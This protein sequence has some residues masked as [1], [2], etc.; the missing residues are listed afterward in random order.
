MEQSENSMFRYIVNLFLIAVI[1]LVLYL[2]YRL[3]SPFLACIF[4]A[5]ILGLIFYPLYKWLLVRTRERK[6]LSSLLTCVVITLCIIVPVSL[7][8]G[9]LTTQSFELYR[10]IESKIADGSLEEILDF[11]GDGALDTLVGRAVGYFDIDTRQLVIE[12]SKGLQSVSGS[13]FSAGSGLVK[14]LSSLV[15]NFLLMIFTLY[16]LF[17]EGERVRDE[18]VH[19]S[20]LST[21]YEKRILDHFHQVTSAS[22]K[23]SILTAL[24]QGVAGGIG[25]AVVG[26]PSAAL[27]GS[28]MA[29][30]ALIPMVGTAIVWIP[31]A[32]YLLATGHLIGGS[33]LILWGALLVGMIDNLLKPVLIKSQTSMHPLLIFFSILG[34]LK[35][36]GFLGLILGPTILALFLTIV[37]IYKEEFRE[38]LEA[39][40][41]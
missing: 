11:S 9:M 10:T 23:G 5:V 4:V 2:V 16:Y 1:S 25:F 18:L 35:A 19:V 30:F 36:F 28:V 20:P 39:Q 38:D 31:A 37:E 21:R 17:I 33:V 6:R 27:W 12:L 24:A 15:I 32:V 3:L 14:N 26:L 22:V 7:M 34:G 40:D 29:F 13:I 41:G 8:I